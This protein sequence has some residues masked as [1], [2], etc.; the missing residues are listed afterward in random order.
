MSRVVRLAY[1]DPLELIWRQC[2]AAL[3]FRLAESPEVYASSDGRGGIVLGCA[4]TLDADDTLA[5]MV[6]HELCHALVQGEAGAGQPD[7]GLD[8][9]SERDVWREHACLRLQAWLTQAWGLREFFAPTTDFRLSFWPLLPAHPLSPIPSLDAEA[10]EQ[11]RVAARV[12]ILRASEPPWSTALQTA[13]AGTRALADAVLSVPSA[14]AAATLWATVSPR[15]ALHPAGH[16][17]VAVDAALQCADCAWAYTLRGRLHCRH[18]PAKALPPDSPA[19]LRHEPASALD[20]RPCAACCREAFDS[21][22]VGP[23]E[24][25]V[26]RHP[27]LITEHHGRLALRRAAGLC[28]ALSVSTNTHAAAGPCYTCRI[29]ADRPR[30]C[31]DFTQASGNCLL[32]RRRVGLSL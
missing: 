14:S 8:N 10:D 16:A 19:C 22:E 30:N 20:C 25:T 3:G 7:W 11:A 12:A 9:T 21:V 2:A 24:R 27:E 1:R 26:K 31:R 23:R 29:Y 32:A 17:S 13:L 4:A 15:P 6:L 28:E 5:Q 18:A